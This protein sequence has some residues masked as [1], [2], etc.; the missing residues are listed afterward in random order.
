V[1]INRG[2]LLKLLRAKYLVPALGYHRVAG[3]PI[4]SVNIEQRIDEILR[5]ER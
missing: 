2:Q 1:E 5:G 3:L 4:P